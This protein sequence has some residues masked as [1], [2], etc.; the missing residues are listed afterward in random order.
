MTAMLDTF[1]ER[2]KKL[3]R[4]MAAAIW[5][6]DLDA[7]EQ[8]RTE[9]AGVTFPVLAEHP[10]LWLEETDSLEPFQTPHFDAVT[11]ELDRWLVPWKLK[12]GYSERINAL[13]YRLEA[14]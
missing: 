14:T 5:G 9:R 12:A 8:L 6:I 11:V 7:V 3:A 1:T 4:G 10:A 13:V 2:E